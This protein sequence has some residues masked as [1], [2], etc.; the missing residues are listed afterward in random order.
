MNFKKA[1]IILFIILTLLLNLNFIVSAYESNDEIENNNISVFYEKNRIITSEIEISSKTAICKSTI[2]LDSSQKIS[3][4]QYL[5]RK[6]GD[7]WETVDSWSKTQ[8][9]KKLTFENKRSYLIAGTYRTR[10][11]AKIFTGSNYEKV[12][13]NSVSK[14]VK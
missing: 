2:F 3:V 11:I 5:Q 4:T 14:I 10:T 9:C 1:I 7:N 8:S 12:I 6:N 13:K